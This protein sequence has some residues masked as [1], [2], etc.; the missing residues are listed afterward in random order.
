MKTRGDWLSDPAKLARDFELI[1]RS[2]MKGNTLR[3]WFR[4][5]LFPHKGD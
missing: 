3:G 1:D 5:V 2:L 4:S